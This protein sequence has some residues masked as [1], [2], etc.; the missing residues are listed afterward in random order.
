MTIADS[1]RYLIRPYNPGKYILKKEF[2]PIGFIRNLFEYVCGVTISRSSLNRM[3]PAFVFSVDGD[4]L[5]IGGCDN[6]FKSLYNK[7]KYLNLDVV[8]SQCIDIVENAED[9][10]SIQ[11]STFSAV[12]CISVLEHT[13]HPEKIVAE[14]YR[15]LK[16]GGVAF[17]S[18]PWMFEAHMEPNDYYRFSD[19]IN[20]ILFDKFIVKQKE[21]INGYFGLLAHLVQRNILLRLTIG[22]VF[23]LLDM[24]LPKKPRWSTEITIIMEKPV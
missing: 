13:R 10:K 8:P 12:I 2:P 1:A 21:F 19:D 24:L 23:L 20:D 4:V 3:K 11:D 7:G 5:E 14:I 15:V 18:N 16:P 17:I 9:M 6:F 22:V